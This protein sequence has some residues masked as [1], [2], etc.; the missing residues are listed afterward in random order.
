M[1][2]ER[3]LERADP[4]ARL[5]AGGLLIVLLLILVAGW[6][7]RRAAGAIRLAAPAFVP[8]TP[9]GAQHVASELGSAYAAL[10]DAER[11]R[12]RAP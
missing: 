4:L 5:G 10:V 3:P 9:E 6:D 11:R 12:D 1:N 2:D 8:I 7:R